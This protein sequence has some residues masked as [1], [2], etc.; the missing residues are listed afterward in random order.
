M[1]GRLDREYARAAWIAL[2]NV[3][4]GTNL[5]A[6]RRLLA[7]KPRDVL[8]FA[9]E[10][11]FLERAM[12]GDRGLRERHVADAFMSSNG[13]SGPPSIR[14]HIVPEET[15][16]FS[17]VTT[18]L[19]D[20]VAL[21]ML[22]RATHAHTVFEIGTLRG[23]STYHLAMNAA[24]GAQILSLDLPRGSS[25]GALAMTP[26][27]RA[28]V[29]LSQVDRFHFTGT[30]EERQ[31]TL[32]H[33]DSATFDFTPWHR[34]VDLFFIDGAHSYEYVRADTLNALACVRPGGVI[35]WHD[36]GRTG[37]N[38]VTRWLREFRDQGHDV[39]IV[40]GCSLA[41]LVV[42]PATMATH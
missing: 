36:A 4:T 1:P 8:S 39:C 34:K 16:W 28:H 30:P 9:L 18:Y 24:A 37:V 12:F 33:G 3:M 25:G 13:G 21:C 10:A 26:I 23:L 2:R 42:G 14:L 32:L 11:S 29:K 22:A 35:A 31:I 38:G 5:R 27:D 41:Y 17:G 40:P 7:G 20:L 19:A 15:A 6:L